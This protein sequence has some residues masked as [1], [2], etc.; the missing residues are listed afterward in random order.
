LIS[1]GILASLHIPDSQ[2]RFDQVEDACEGTFGWL[3]E[4]QELGFVEWL[5]RG[6]GI[7][8]ISGKPA[9][10]KSTL[11]KYAVS[12]SRTYGYL[13]QNNP[14]NSWVCG[15]F[16]FTN[17]G[18]H[19][20]KSIDGLLQRILYQLLS[21]VPGLA[22]FIE[23][24]FM[25][26]ADV[27]GE[28]ILI[29]L[30]DALMKI[31]RQRKLAINICLF[32]DALDEHN[33][34]YHENHSRLV[35]L[36]QNLIEASDG[37]II[38]VMLCL[39][40]RPENLFK[41][42]FWG[43]PG[44]RIHEHTHLDVQVYVNTRMNM[45]LRS[46]PDLCTDARTMGSLNGTI[47]EVIRRAQGVFLWVRLVVTDIIEG[48]IDG[49]SP[50]KLHQNLS[51]IPGDGDLQ[52]LYSG[53][54]LRMR[55]NYLRE[56]FAMLQ[57][58]Y[59]AIEPMQFRHFFQALHITNFGSANYDWAVPT[60]PEMERKLLS[61]CRGFLEVQ[62]SFTTDEQGSEYNGLVVQFLHQSV[63]DFLRH[64][65]SFEDIRTKLKGMFPNLHGWLSENG[66]SF[67]LRFRVCQHFRRYGAQPYLIKRLPKFDL[68]KFE[69][70]YH[71]NMAEMYLQRP[72]AEPLD[73]LSDFADTNG[74]VP[75]YMRHDDWYVPES[76]QPTFLALAVQ[77]G[78]VL[79][80]QYTFQ[81]RYN[82]R[83]LPGRPLLHYSVLPM[84]KSLCRRGTD[85][86]LR[87]PKMV[88]LLVQL[89]ADIHCKFEG[90]TAFAFVFKECLKGQISSGQ[91]RMLEILLTLGSSTEVPV[92][93]S[94][95]NQYVGTTDGLGYCGNYRSEVLITPLQLAVRKDNLE[96]VSLLLRFDARIESLTDEDWKFLRKGYL[97]SDTPPEFEDFPEAT[98]EE[99]LQS[100]LAEK[101]RAI[102][103]GKNSKPMLRLVEDHIQRRRTWTSPTSGPV[104]GQRPPPESG[105]LSFAPQYP[106]I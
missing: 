91:L 89:G 95:Q 31:V 74:L 79:Y 38:K 97:Y 32:I 25:Q 9:S 23:Q 15:N 69:V 48:L 42:T 81:R 67:L 93:W 100:W 12:N 51:A 52:E 75:F 39:T 99:Q 22:K 30:E 11:L 71:A 13:R 103:E 68:R 82:I 40:S 2:E 87:S 35:Q 78:L 58:A 8:W 63:K 70:L 20:Q 34:E 24:I 14:R 4:K 96:A 28:W 59:S 6:S 50:D 21:Q 27:Q 101:E 73:A 43:C 18:K 61:R 17:R 10:G 60:E 72:I 76:W 102:R 80:V 1:K 105:I 26:H 16:F 65:A 49:D 106:I 45:Y 92:E 62:K 86:F 44:F 94:L 46:R 47:K 53:I 84:P 64:S 37:K 54:L 83:M 57:I 85:P 88:K 5:R 3:Y 36:L 56:A 90:L 19:T 29:Y 77:A 41:D 98:K 33:E 66:H 7:F 55:P 104:L